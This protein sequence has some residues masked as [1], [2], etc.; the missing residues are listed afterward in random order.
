MKIEVEKWTIEK[1]KKA[2]NGIELTKHL[3]KLCN[4]E[5]DLYTR[6]ELSGF[7]CTLAIMGIIEDYE[8][9][10]IVGKFFNVYTNTA[11]Y[12]YNPE[13]DPDLK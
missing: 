2:P 8:A 9:N 5:D 12:P 13:E 11:L 1:I 6:G 4:A 7:L 10:K 3:V